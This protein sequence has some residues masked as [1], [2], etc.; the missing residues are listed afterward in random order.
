MRGRRCRVS[1]RLA[2]C[3]GSAR[4]MRICRPRQVGGRGVEAA[5]GQARCK[6]Q[7][8]GAG[9]QAEEAAHS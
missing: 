8:A 1:A 7:G 3:T 5:A 2:P 4:L 9:G 6:E